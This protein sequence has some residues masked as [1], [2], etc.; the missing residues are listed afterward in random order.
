MKLKSPHLYNVHARVGVG[1]I[2]EILLV[3]ST[4]AFC[5]DTTTRGG[6]IMKTVFHLRRVANH[7][8]IATRRPKAS[9][10]AIATAHV[11]AAGGIFRRSQRR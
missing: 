4:A 7:K 11:A 8:L 2:E 6:L 10:A 5:S 1:F 3:V 9:A